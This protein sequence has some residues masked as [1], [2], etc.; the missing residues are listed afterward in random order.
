MTM[1]PQKYQI[2]PIYYNTIEIFNV[3]YILVFVKCLL[4]TIYRTKHG[5][6]CGNV[7]TPIV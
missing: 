1:S 4:Y 2:F 7:S 5:T 6:I 3:K